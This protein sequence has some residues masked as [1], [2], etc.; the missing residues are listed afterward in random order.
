MNKL[1]ML[2]VATFVG[3]GAFHSEAQNNSSAAPPAEKTPVQKEL[4]RCAKLSIEER[5]HDTACD[6]AAKAEAQQFIGN[7][8]SS[9]TPQPVN[10]FP[11]VPDQPFKP[12]TPN[13]KTPSM[14]Q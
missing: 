7:G 1:A 14:G 9:Y 2:A 12:S 13:A 8:Q 6:A 5:V 10:P 11:T 4:D 3:I